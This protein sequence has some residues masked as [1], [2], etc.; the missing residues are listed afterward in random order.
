MSLVLKKAPVAPISD[1]VL[2]Y[3]CPFCMTTRNCSVELRIMAHNCVEGN[4]VF[5]LNGFALKNA[6]IYNAE[7]KAEVER[8]RKGGP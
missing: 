7:V 3:T 4:I 6:A 1:S 2:Q 5:F 8:K